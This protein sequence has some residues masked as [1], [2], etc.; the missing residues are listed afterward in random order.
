MSYTDMAA[1]VKRFFA[2]H[3]LKNHTLIGHSLGGKVAMAMA[4][5]PSLPSGTLSHLV[6]VDMSPAE[7]PISP[8]FMRY[9]RTMLEIER[10]NVKQRSEA[11]EILQ[12]VEPNLGVRQFLLTN[13]ERGENGM[14]FRIPVQTMIDSLEGIGLFPYALGKDGAPPER[15]WDGPT[16]FVKGEHSKYINK[17][18]VPV[19]QA[20]FP[21]MKLVELPTGHWVQSESPRAFLG[22][23]R[24]FLLE[25]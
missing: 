7:G 4:L 23:V 24:E 18:N 9:A 25:H 6:S 22:C 15:Q 17:H 12:K 5:D 13:L 2:D 1:D 21:S 19:C 11:D 20:F 16:L 8:E 3:K 10:A 14:H